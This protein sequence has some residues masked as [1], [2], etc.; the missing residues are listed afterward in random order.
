MVVDAPTGPLKDPLPLGAG[1]A[2]PVSRTAPV[3]KALT[4]DSEKAMAP[5][6]STFA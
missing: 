2:E 3:C 4:Q 6:S 5:H 1:I